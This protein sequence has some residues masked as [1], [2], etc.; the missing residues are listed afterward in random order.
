MRNLGI[1]LA[2]I[3]FV[4][5]VGLAGS[6]S[7]V[8]DS[9]ACSTPDGVTVIVDSTALGGP[10]SA[11]CA[12]GTQQSGLEALRRAGFS[13]SP[14]SSQPSMVCRIDGLPGS[15]DQ[16]CLSSPP[17]NA[18]WA[19]FRANRGGEW[20]YSSLGAASAPIPGGVEGWV[21]LRGGR[22]APEMAPPAPFGSGRV[23]EPVGS[24]SPK[25]VKPSTPST[26][27]TPSPN[28]AA[29]G[30]KSPSATALTTASAVA[31]PASEAGEVGTS[32][33]PP[34]V[35][36]AELDVSNSVLE[37]ESAGGGS[38]A[39]MLAGVGILGG[40]VVAAVV[41]GVRRRSSS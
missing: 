31:P 22:E 15:G 11:K 39:S 14:V 40:L 19:Y 2:S 1:L 6:S 41:I 35:V 9:G 33:S 3:G 21:Y 17:A 18:Y 29:T 10:V 37:P 16:S 28:R 27:T 8:A 36:A 20:K 5:A 25:P 12:N 7:A 24:A 30:K 26:T 38:G 32:A 4:G 13:W 34:P 23:V